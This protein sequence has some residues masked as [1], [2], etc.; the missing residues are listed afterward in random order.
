ML[1]QLL[2]LAW[3]NLS[4]DVF[5][6]DTGVDL[7]GKPHSLVNL[8]GSRSWVALLANGALVSGLLIA[9]LVAFRSS[10]NVM[11]L[12]LACCGI[13]YA[14]QGPPLRLSYH[15]LGEP[16]CWLVFGPLATAAALMAINPL[17]E[18]GEIPW[19]SAFELG[20]GPAIATT[21][22]LFCSH[23]HQV[24]EDFAHGKYSPV[25]RLG[26]GPAASLIPWFVSL[27]FAFEWW[28]ILT[29][30]WPITG[31]FSALG[32]PAGIELIRLLKDHHQ[33]PK[34]IGN[35]K[36]LA[37]RFQALNG[38]GLSLGLAVSP[39]FGTTIQ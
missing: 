5:D 35:S 26:T 24:K 4:N 11:W 37:L 23:F 8:T 9:S 15:G 30:V 19:Y 27:T 10:L 29:G 31:L 38:V 21:L 39:W 14:Y 33:E 6:S 36:F 1:L 34:R 3:E 20:S 16:L 32:L 28:P 12:I 7:N 22:V 18:G 17:Y 2:L 13:G 25:V